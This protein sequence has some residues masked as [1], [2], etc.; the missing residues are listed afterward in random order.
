M[1]RIAVIDADIILYKA[2]RVAEEE[3]NWGND[4]YVLWSNLN[5]VKTIIDDQIDLIVDEM[6]A[7]RSILCFS[8]KNNYRKEINPEYK[9][10]RREKKGATL[11]EFKFDDG[12]SSK[13][14]SK[15]LENLQEEHHHRFCGEAVCNIVIDTTQ[16]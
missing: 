6:E 12:I 1:D 11:S 10:N 16:E 3:V 14:L 7:D 4:Q 2:C 13:D 8:D 15:F 9:A 5:L